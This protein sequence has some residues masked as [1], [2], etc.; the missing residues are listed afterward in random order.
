M[1]LEI[2]KRPGKLEIKCFLLLA[3]FFM[4]CTSSIPASSYEL[5][6]GTGPSGSFSHHTGKFLC[7]I[8]AKQDEEITCSLS[9]S[10]DPTDN[11]TNVQGGALDLALIDS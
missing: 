1:I 2:F 10:N 7:R 6:I 9:A 4:I 8:F 5:I 3:A 11:L